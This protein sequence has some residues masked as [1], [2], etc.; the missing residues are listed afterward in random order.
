VDGATGDSADAAKATQQAMTRVRLR[1]CAI[2][3]EDAEAITAFV[4]LRN[5]GEALKGYTLLCDGPREMAD[6][7]IEATGA[8]Q[9]FRDHMGE[10]GRDDLEFA[11]TMMAGVARAAMQ[12]LD[13]NLRIWPLP[14]LLAQ[15]DPHVR[16][17]FASIN[18]LTPVPR[19]R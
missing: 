15:Y 6:L 16:R 8:M 11:I 3:D 14:D 17:L 19:I 12:L 2:A 9:N 4:E 10:R 5:R 7:A 13:S 18:E 1:M